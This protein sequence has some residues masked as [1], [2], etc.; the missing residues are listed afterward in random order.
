MP[1]PRDISTIRKPGPNAPGRRCAGKDC[2]TVLS[3][4]SDGEFCGP[5]LEK[6]VPLPER[7]ASFE[8]L[9]REAA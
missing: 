5:C 6:L 2:I 7:P 1:A 8:Q 4:Y 3:R 9:M